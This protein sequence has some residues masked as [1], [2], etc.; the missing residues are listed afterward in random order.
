M[1][2][3]IYIFT[4]IVFTLLVSCSGVSTSSTAITSI[5]N[6]TSPAL[7]SQSTADIPSLES[8]ADVR[9]LDLSGVSE[10]GISKIKTLWFDQTTT[11]NEEDRIL[12]EKILE[13]GRSPGKEIIELHN[14]GINGKG[15]TVAIIDQSLDINHPEFAGKVSKYRSFGIGTESGTV[16]MHGPAV[17]SLLVGNDI[18]TAPDS[19]VYYAAVPSW[20]LDAQYYAD[21]LDWLVNENEALPMGKKIRVVSISAAP[22]GIWSEF[23]KNQPAYD[24]AYLRAT[25]AG[26]LVLDCTAEHGI[27][28]ACTKDVDDLDNSSDCSPNWDPAPQTGRE[29][30]YINTAR[31][32]ATEYSISGG[33]TYGYQYTGFGGLSWTT[34]YLAG[35]FAMA[36]QVNPDISNAQLTSILF[37]TAVVNQQGLIVIDPRSFIE[38]VNSIN[39]D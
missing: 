7:S 16:S 9:G 21:A 20:M 36:W 1:K 39:V 25:E 23:S 37:E 28:L 6:T 26:I 17:T 8:Y 27:T 24:A 30:I 14:E 13:N 10:I 34:P 33:F 2:F 35:L 15:I 19:L 12:T 31:T 22:S 5:E 38:K 29:R 4:L 3:P 11:W 18:G 32:T